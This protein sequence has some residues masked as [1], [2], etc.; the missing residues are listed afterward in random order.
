MARS[1]RVDEHREGVLMAAT[2][3][4]RGNDRDTAVGIARGLSAS[5]KRVAAAHWGGTDYVFQFD[6]MTEEE[7]EAWLDAEYDR[8]D[9]RRSAGARS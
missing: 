2:T 4:W 3:V 7:I 8:L 6:G 1:V 5:G 9:S